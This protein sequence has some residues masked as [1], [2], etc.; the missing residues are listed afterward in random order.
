MALLT[1]QIEALAPL[2][3]PERKPSIQFNASLPYVPGAAIFGA[4]GQYLGPTGFDEALFRALRCHNA[5]PAYPGDGWVRPL[6]ATAITPK[7]ADEEAPLK[8]S[9]Y[10]RVAWEIQQPPALIYAPTDDDGRPWE[11]AGSRFYTLTATGAIATRSLQQRVLT[12]VGINRQRGTAQN[13]RL[14]SPLVISEVDQQTMAPATFLGSVSAPDKEA[15]R[16]SAALEAISHLGA[17][18]T[19]GLGVVHLRRQI[20]EEPPDSASA[21]LQ[22]I[23][24]MTRRFRA[25]A[26]RYERLGGSPWPIAETSIFT[27]NLLSDAILFEDGWLP[28][29]ELSPQLLEEAT[30]TANAAGI[31]AKLLRS[32]TATRTVGGW[33]SL[34]QRPKA[35]E[36]AVLMGGLY[37][38]QAERSL[39]EADCEQ[40]AALERDGI[41][42]RRAEG[43]GQVRICDDF[44][45]RD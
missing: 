25:Q 39:T 36:V 18:Q 2:A 15:D 19:T 9:L 22:R 31:K 8:D 33:H 14:Y 7:G 17:R 27:V 38:F 24:T 29:Q 32:F 35:A 45:L 11:A 28:T 10:P 12:R 34:W 13:Q 20:A 43:F 44:H 42:E 40:L 1:I 37:V 16:I 6:T 4:L 30:S 41:G 21:I 26:A 5:Y 3:F 23:E